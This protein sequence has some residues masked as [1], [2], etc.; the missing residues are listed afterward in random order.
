MFYTEYTE[1]TE[2]EVSFFIILAPQNAMAALWSKEVGREGG[3][4]SALH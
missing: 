2:R 4:A 1:G 3:G